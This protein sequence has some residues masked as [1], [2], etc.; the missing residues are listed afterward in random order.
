MVGWYPKETTVL[1]TFKGERQGVQVTALQ[2]LLKNNQF[3]HKV[4][5]G[6][7]KAGA[8]VKLVQSKWSSE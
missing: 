7:T 1:P 5:Q 8:I 6:A 3:G 4:L 2:N